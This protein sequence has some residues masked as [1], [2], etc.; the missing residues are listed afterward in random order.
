M[1][2]ILNMID[3]DFNKSDT[4]PLEFDRI[5][6]WQKLRKIKMALDMPTI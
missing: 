1:I 5:K 6:I 3:L 2:H 4:S